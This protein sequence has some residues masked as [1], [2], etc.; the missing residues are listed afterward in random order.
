MALIKVRGKKPKSSRQIQPEGST[1]NLSPKSKRAGKD[2]EMSDSEATPPADGVPEPVLSGLEGLPPE[3]LEDIFWRCPNLDFLRASKRLLD[4]LSSALSSEWSKKKLVLRAFSFNSLTKLPKWDPFGTDTSLLSSFSSRFG[5]PSG[6]HNLMSEPLDARLQ[7]Q[8]LRVRW[9]TLE[10]LRQC[11][12]EY[13]TQHLTNWYQFYRPSTPRGEQKSAIVDMMERLQFCL[14]RVYGDVSVTTPNKLSTFE[15]S[16][17]QPRIGSFHFELIWDTF[18]KVKIVIEAT[19]IILINDRFDNKIQFP[20]FVE[21]CCLPERLLHGPW[22][23][24]KCKSLKVLLS[25]GLKIDWINSTAG[26]VARQG[27]RD[28]ILEQNTFALDCLLAGSSFYH[29]FIADYRMRGPFARSLDISSAGVVPN[30]GDLIFALETDTP[31]AVIQRLLNRCN[32]QIDWQNTRLQDWATEMKVQGD[33]RGALLQKH[34]DYFAQHRDWNCG[35]RNPSP[36]DRRRS[37]RKI[38]NRSRREND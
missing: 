29:G 28:A 9:M 1:A 30:T 17:S 23:P 38:K 3:L 11:Q 6:P 21:G 22:T 2:Q 24:T 20:A 35:K 31:E 4:V 8:L 18:D 13:F 32:R 15:S 7:D 34:L 26:E 19:E 12:E 25:H 5:K 10:F 33:E 36:A 37:K 14:Q 27:L 16:D